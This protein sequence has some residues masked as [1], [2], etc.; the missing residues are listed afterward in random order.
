MK[1]FSTLVLVL[2]IL[3]SSSGTGNA[4]NDILKGIFEKEAPVF[5]ASVLPTEKEGQVELQY[6]FTHSK[7]D[8]LDISVW[9]KD[10]GANFLDNGE[11]DMVS[12]LREA[13]NRRENRLLI[14]NLKELHFYTIGIDYRN[15]N[16]LVRKFTSIVLKEG[17][18]Y[19]GPKVDLA[20]NEMEK[21]AELPQEETVETEPCYNPDF[22]IKVDPS[23]YCQTGNRPAVFIQCDNCQGEEWSFSVEVR[24]EYGEWRALRM[25][26]ERQPAAGVALRTEPLCALNPGIYRVRVL[27]WGSNCPD[28][29]IENIKTTIIIGDEK[30]VEDLAYAE[31]EEKEIY[32]PDQ[33][34]LAGEATLAGNII[35][36]TITLDAGSPCAEYR[37]FARIRYI[38]PG[39]RDLSIDDIPLIPG[40]NMTFEFELDDLDLN[41]GIQTI[42][43]VEFIRPDQVAQ[44]LE[45]RSFWIKAA[46]QAASEESVSPGFNDDIF[47]TEDEAAVQEEEMPEFE[48]VAEKGGDEYSIDEQMMETVNVRATDPNCNQIRDLQLVYGSGKANVPLYIS[49]LSPRCCQEEGCSY[50]VWAG[51]SYDRPRLLIKGNKPAPVV[52]EL[53]QNIRSDDMYFEVVVETSNGTR[54]AAYALGEG[55]LYG[56]EE[57]LDY[58]DSFNEPL[59]GGAMVVGQPSFAYAEPQ[60]SIAEFRSCRIYRETSMEAGNP[61]QAGEEIT[62]KYHFTEKGYKYTLYQRPEGAADWFVAPGTRELTDKAEFTFTAQPEHSGA[63]LV[64]AYN[65]DLTWGCLSKPISEPLEIKVQAGDE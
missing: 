58:H 18:R 24:S 36:G 56:I 19:V 59:D 35:R 9:I 12:G 34:G 2:F 63:Y 6:Y 60:L 21:A 43:V 52:K 37:P 5:T 27:A 31:Q 33:C 22:S 32:I 13:G 62:V 47:A 20:A 55:P 10:L 64:L 57:I 28:P 53:L 1:R 65:P 42:Q 11:K 38:H 46:Q 15:K 44:D 49:W 29:V 39:H 40:S 17:F 3:V 26:G 14:E 54:K 41:R 30:P 51:E 45:V 50:T 48:E 7:V 23:G 16:G 8:A 25:D 61:V 4:Q